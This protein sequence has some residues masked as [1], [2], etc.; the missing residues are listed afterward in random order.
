MKL[1]NTLILIA[2]LMVTG[3]SSYPSFSPTNWWHASKP[4]TVTVL[5]AAPD[6]AAIA[7]NNQLQIAN[8]AAAT[9]AVELANAR[10]ENNALLS[11]LKA[12]VV[13]AA[14]ANA[15]NPVGIPKTKVAGELSVADARLVNITVDPV[16]AAA[17]ANRALL[18]EQGRTLEA[19]SAY[20][21]AVKDGKQQAADVATANTR[22]ISAYAGETAANAAVA[23]IT[24]KYEALITENQATNMKHLAAVENAIQ[25]DQVRNLNIAG[26]LCIVLL[27]LG[28]GF[29]GVG[30]LK[31]TYPFGIMAAVLF[32]LAQVVG[33]LW[34]HYAVIGGLVVAIIAAAVYLWQLMDEKK[35]HL[36]VA[37]NA[38][39][40]QSVLTQ[41]VP[42]LDK[43]YE[44]AGADGKKIL[45]DAVFTPLATV[46]D[47]SEKELVHQIRGK[48]ETAVT[49]GVTS[50]LPTT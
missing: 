37:A 42:V 18:V 46:M 41:V 23:T 50:S 2:T 35:T 1:R 4:S 29:G 43:A 38:D 12:N 45:D 33:S 36:G 10:A 31:M 6:T 22:A 49:G 47:R 14:G 5:P 15:D 44:K 20:A 24:S 28:V 48:L 40:L 3:C 21:A 30:G 13:S 8:Q 25:S 17:A 7:L 9:A 39:K 16:E 11:K 34:F 32:G 26:G 27:G 19:Q